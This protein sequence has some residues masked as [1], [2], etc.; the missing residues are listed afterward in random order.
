V[1]DA[2]TRAPRDEDTDSENPFRRIFVNAG[3]LTG[4]RIGGDLANLVLFVV[5][6]RTFGPEGIGQYAYAL[7]IAGLMYALVNLG[8]EDF[9]VRECARTRSA[10][11]GALVGRLLLMQGVAL[12]IASLM[13]WVFLGYV[14]RTVTGSI[15]VASLVLQQV[16]LAFARTLFSPSFG[17][18]KMTAPA[19]AEF[20]TRLLG[21]GGS[22]TLV[23]LYN[24]NL[25]VTLVPLPV[26]GLLLLLY[27]IRSYHSECPTIVFSAKWVE[28]RPIINQAWPFAGALFLSIA[29]LRSNFIILNLMLGD[30][31]TG[32]YATGVKL[33]E[34]AAIPIS[35]L[36][37]A[38]YPRLSHLYRSSR[39]EFWSAGEDLIRVT[40]FVGVLVSWAL[41]FVAPY[42]VEPLFGQNF[43]AS[44][45]VVRSI[46]G[47]G[48]LAGLGVILI[49][50][51]LASD[52]QHI[53]LANQAITLVIL[54]I[55]TVA[56]IPFLG[57]YGAVLGTYAS[58]VAGILIMTA[59]LGLTFGRRISKI[60]ISLFIALSIASFS[61]FATE[62]LATS[63]IWSAFASITTFLAVA[64]WLRL[65]PIGSRFIISTPRW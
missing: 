4:G 43:A 11:R 62:M 46:A 15:L 34:A 56:L 29:A 14:G 65:L 17:E 20:I 9:A 8:L 58:A 16:F 33:M 49:R 13:L 63:P 44:G 48:L 10:E 61:T 31:E 28:I 57:V 19:I 37:F 21:I 64:A 5:L 25:A 40:V 24:T 22:L 36:G 18:Q 12:L 30:A 59:I 53:R 26:G 27:A 52:R 47:R 39:E 41:F 38:A 45:P 3:W 35:L 7:G 42:V 2:R 50:L 51:L 32:V 23:G 54:L 60:M 1:S 55:T 6:A